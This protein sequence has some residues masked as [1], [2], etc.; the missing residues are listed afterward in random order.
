MQKIF[1]LVPADDDDNDDDDDGGND[2]DGDHDDVSIH[3]SSICLLFIYKESLMLTYSKRAILTSDCYPAF[4]PYLRSLIVILFSL[5][6]IVTVAFDPRAYLMIVFSLQ[7][8]CHHISISQL[9]HAL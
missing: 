2:D 7:P 5:M 1:S 9:Q 6:L 3:T 8:P 4:S